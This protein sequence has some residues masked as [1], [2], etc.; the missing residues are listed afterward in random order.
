MVRVIPQVSRR[1]TEPPRIGLR[2]KTKA[3]PS[4]RQVSE[5]P[6]GSLGGLKAFVGQGLFWDT[7]IS[8]DGR[9]VLLG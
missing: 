3:K 6:D 5:I 2:K 4:A 8:L 9:L 7:F 1:S